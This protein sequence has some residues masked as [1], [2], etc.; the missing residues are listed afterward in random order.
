MK[1]LFAVATTGTL[2]LSGI[3]SAREFPVY[4]L[5]GFP[6]SPD[7]ISIM[8]A[9]VNLKEQSPGTS[10]TMDGMPASPVQILVLTPHQRAPEERGVRSDRQAHPDVHV[11][12]LRSH[13]GG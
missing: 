6:I 9:T 5:S 1:T 11:Q 7:E 12:A 10:L 4:E 2:L 13:R 8:G 3:A